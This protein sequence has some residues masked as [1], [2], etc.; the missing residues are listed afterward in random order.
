MV[1]PET[2]PISFTYSPVASMW[3][4]TLYNLFIY[5]DPSLPWHP[6]SYSLRLFSS[7]TFFRINIPTFSKLV[8][9]H[10][11]P[12]M[13]MEQ[14]ECSATSAYNIQTQGNYPEES[15]LRVFP[16]LEIYFYFITNLNYLLRFI[17]QSVHFYVYKLLLRN[18]ARIV[19]QTRLYNAIP[20]MT[21]NI[22]KQHV[23]WNTFRME[24]KSEIKR[25]HR[26][27]IR[28]CWHCI[29]PC[30]ICHVN[31]YLPTVNARYL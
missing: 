9:L 2:R 5:S 10:T 21:L 11:Y 22:V 29:K 25:G 1:H 27:H 14:T 7:Q 8:I 28:L 12:P 4:V 30:Y 19:H 15:I 3:V 13:K 23:Y 26:E 17:C 31:F 24:L 20:R 6:P 16:P 18:R